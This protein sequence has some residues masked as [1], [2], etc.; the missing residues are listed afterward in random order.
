[1]ATPQNDGVVNLMK[2]ATGMN[3]GQAGTMPGS[4]SRSATG[5]GF[6]YSRSKAAVN[7]GVTFTVEWSDTLTSASWSHAYVTET[8]SDQGDT[9]LVT[10]TVPA[11]A[12]PQR[13]VRLK[14]TG[15]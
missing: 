10:A 12:G 11:A 14:V 13:F 7:D 15:R 8:A 6:T 2:F 5:L 9:Q 4:S 1:M 3:P